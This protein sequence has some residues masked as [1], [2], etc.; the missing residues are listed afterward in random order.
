MSDYSSNGG[1][2]STI[3]SQVVE[4]DFHG[5]KIQTFMH[6]G[7]P[8]VAMRRVVENMRMDWAR[9]FKKLNDQKEKFNCCLMSTVGS[10]GKWRE[11]LSMP[12]QKLPLW[13]ASINP[14]KIKDEEKRATIIRY[15]EESAIAL[16][17]YWTK[18]VTFRDDYDGMVTDISPE[19]MKAIGGMVK[20]IVVKALE[21]RVNTLVEARL[22]ADP[23]VAA[24][25]HVP[26]LQVIVDK[27]IKPRVRGLAQK[28][29]HSLTRFC[30]VRKVTILRDLG[31]RKLFPREMV[32]EWLAQGGWNEVKEWHDTRCGQPRF[33]LV[34]K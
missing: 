5:D 33:K 20:G 8:W 6:N 30:E 2:L 23:R 13:M 28:V 15:Q 17:G 29:S 27:K 16:H 31:N 26:A 18:G 32:N 24:V 3:S 12:V 14:N 1:Q 21:E 7:E 25:K 22:S 19:A 10:D 9:Q 4:I 11:M 34:K